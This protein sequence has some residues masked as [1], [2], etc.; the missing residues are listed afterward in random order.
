[1]E[2]TDHIKDLMY[3]TGMTRLEAEAYTCCIEGGMTMTEYA[4]AIGRN[5]TL[6][7]ARL[8]NARR[9]KLE[10]EHETRA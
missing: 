3:D 9:K 1:M 6:V 10:A 4:T 8:S 7:S 5:R 2:D